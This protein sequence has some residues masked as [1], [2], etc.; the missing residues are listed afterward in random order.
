MQ[1]VTHLRITDIIGTPTAK[2]QR[3][4]GAN[5]MRNPS[6]PLHFDSHNPFFTC[7]SRSRVV[8]TTQE[9]F[10]Y[11]FKNFVNSSTDVEIFMQ[12]KTP[13]KSTTIY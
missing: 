2:V 6:R 10:E 4:S 11:I 9:Q 12:L 5:M 8:S 13:M 7:R 3:D 1:K